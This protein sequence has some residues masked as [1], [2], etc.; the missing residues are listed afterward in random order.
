MEEDLVA[1]L[2]AAA[3]VAALVGDRIDWNI[4]PQ[5]GGLPAI[6]LH[7]ITGGFSYTMKGRSS[8]SSP[9]VQIDCWGG[10]FKQAKSTARAVQAV[11]EGLHKAHPRFQGVFVEDARD[12]FEAGDGPQPDGATNFH[13]SSLD[14]RVWHTE[15]P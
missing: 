3:G 7:R 15:A 6:A 9:L 10:T 11:L 14:V 4:L 8:T 12:T 5:G 2:L 1:A 13:R